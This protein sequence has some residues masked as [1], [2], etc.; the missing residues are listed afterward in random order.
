MFLEQGGLINP[1]RFMVCDKGILYNKS[2]KSNY[3]QENLQIVDTVI[4]Y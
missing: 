4:I 3:V 1:V 2:C